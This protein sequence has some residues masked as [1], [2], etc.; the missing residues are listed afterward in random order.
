MYAADLLHVI[1]RILKKVKLLFHLFTLFDRTWAEIPPRT[2][3]L[4]WT[5]SIY[6][7]IDSSWMKNAITI[8]N[9]QHI[10]LVEN[11]PLHTQIF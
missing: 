9:S 3:L 1:L 5:P 4:S 11:I 6:D 10:L 8:K 2:V 7:L